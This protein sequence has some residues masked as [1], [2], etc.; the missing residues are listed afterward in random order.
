MEEIKIEKTDLLVA[1]SSATQQQKEILKKLYGKEIFATDWRD[2]KSYEKACEFLGIQPIEF[3]ESGDRPK[4]M[5]MIDATNQLLVICEALNG[6]GK[7]YD[8]MGCGYHP[9]FSL[10][11]DEDIKGASS[12]GINPNE[13][14]KLISADY[15]AG[16]D[17]SG[18]LLSGVNCRYTD[19]DTFFAFPICLNSR[20]KAEFVGKQFFKLCLQCYGI[21]VE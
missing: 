20:E 3:S 16:V 11:T 19:S 14:H 18:V 5:K 4:Y 1:Y 8:G 2:I 10:L 15:A 6:N 21:T 9:V 7:C 13:I 12:E 17:M